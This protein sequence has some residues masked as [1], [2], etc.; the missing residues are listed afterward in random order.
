MSVERHA[1]LDQFIDPA[2]RRELEDRYWNPIASTG[3]M[4]RILTD[5]SFAADPARHLGLFADHSAV[6]ARDIALRLAE[7][8]A[9]H[10]GGLFAERSPDRL[11]FMQSYGVLL[12]FLHD[13]GM[14]EDTAEG[15]KMHAQFA[16]QLV[17]R[18]EFEPILDGVLEHGPVAVR[19]AD[20]AA[21]NSTAPA[22]LLREMLAMALCHSK[23]AMPS[24]RL[25]Q[26]DELRRAMTVGICVNL[27]AQY[28]AALAG[29]WTS[30]SSQQSSEAASF[31]ADTEAF[32]WLTNRTPPEQA[33][34]ADV[35]DT[36]RMLRVADA[37]RQRGTDLRT[38]AGFEVFV[39]ETG[40]AVF[41]MADEE[42]AASIHIRIDS[43]VSAG[44]AH[45]HHAVLEP[46]GN[47]RVGFN[48][49]RFDGVAFDRMVRACAIVL[50]DVAADVLDA[51][52]L[53]R[54]PEIEI[55]RS[56]DNPD[57]AQAVSDAIADKRPDLRGRVLIVTSLAALCEVERDRYL[58]GEPVTW[59][60][61]FADRVLAEQR[62]CGVRTDNLEPARCF[63]GVRVVQLHAGDSVI[64]QGES[65]SFVYI[66]T[67]VGLELLSGAGFGEKPLPP[68][69]QV[70][71]TGV[72]R[73]GERNSSIVATRDLAVIMIPGEVYAE[74]W[75]RPYE[76]SDLAGLRSVR[77]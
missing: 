15:R 24:S 71:A 6:H 73:R 41:A 20:V 47:L 35:L 18:P 43:P 74:A 68:W 36:V 22:L 9:K 61:S 21:A 13:V 27:K 46:N 77:G 32:E 19:V 60:S 34:T 23:S 49:G 59:P 31:Y 69:N 53:D 17:Y 7:L 4:E 40:Q 3:S 66:P 8:L 2:I 25:A 10:H 48:R 63:D 50:L 14:V 37:L 1:A 62:R 52:A 54:E 70:G 58:R 64:T 56:V 29:D 57:F 51:F 45:L 38:S 33:L 67:D 26:M 44:E 5:P 16:A 12:A 65:A 72:L 39:D 76:A 75:F 28:E 55:E 11:A 42:L 30:A